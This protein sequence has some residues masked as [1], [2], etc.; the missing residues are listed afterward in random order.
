LKKI[1]LSILTLILVVVVIGCT[2]QSDND[3]QKIQDLKSE[4]AN[5]QMP[6]SISGKNVTSIN[7]QKQNL[8]KDKDI[9]AKKRKAA[10]DFNAE[11]YDGKK[12]T[13]SD[14]KGKLIL[15]D[16]WATWC[17]PSLVEKHGNNE[18][19][20]IIGVSL[21]RDKKGIPEFHKKYKIDYPHVFDGKG[22]KNAVAQLYGV[23]SIPMTYLISPEFEIIG[24][25]YRGEQLITVINSYLQ[26]M[27]KTNS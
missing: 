1:L 15:L 14:H 7:L 6:N 4:P 10:R 11:T 16:F 12:I 24:T 2:K 22:W 17:G 21:D 5:K 20:V 9:G 27:E 8:E 3:K 26:E 19:L 13:L 25:G 18:N 23:R